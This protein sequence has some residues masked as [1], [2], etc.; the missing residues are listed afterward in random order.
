MERWRQFEL[1]RERQDAAS[2][3]NGKFL[4]QKRCLECR[5]P[6]GQRRELK[7]ILLHISMT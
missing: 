7:L 6:K 4:L 2:E 1:T 5:A 3:K